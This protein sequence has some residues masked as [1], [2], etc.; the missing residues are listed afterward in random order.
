MRACVSMYVCACVLDCVSDVQ[1][2]YCADNYFRI[3]KRT[4]SNN[5]GSSSS[6]TSVRILDVKRYGRWASGL[7]VAFLLVSIINGGSFGRT[8]GF[9]RVSYFY[10]SLIKIKCIFML[11]VL[12]SIVFLLCIYVD[13]SVI[14]MFCLWGPCL[15]LCSQMAA[16]KESDGHCLRSEP[17][18]TPNLQLL[19]RLPRGESAGARCCRARA[20]WS[21]FVHSVL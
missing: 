14:C 18:A 1:Y 19:S 12:L 13:C 10:L 20:M 7:A 16:A 15:L 11:F 21:C 3:A 17:T 8:R 6:T 9:A 2:D 5:A 4:L